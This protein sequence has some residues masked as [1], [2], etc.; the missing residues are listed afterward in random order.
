[1]VIPNIFGSISDVRLWTAV[2]KTQAEISASK[3]TLC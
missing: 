1:M 3:K 2:A